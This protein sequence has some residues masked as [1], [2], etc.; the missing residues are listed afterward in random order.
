VEDVSLVSRGLAVFTQVCG[1][2][3]RSATLFTV[4]FL[5]R[6]LLHESSWTA[7]TSPQVFHCFSG[8]KSEVLVWGCLLSFGVSS[9][10]S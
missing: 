5:R 1:K 10:C 9:E 2:N 8:S 4:L 6:V 3:H 7:T